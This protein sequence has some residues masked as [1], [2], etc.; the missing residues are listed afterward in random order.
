MW[1]C[2]LSC[3]CDTH[4]GSAL[5]TNLCWFS[6][7]KELALLYFCCPL[8][9]LFQSHT[10]MFPFV[11]RDSSNSKPPPPKKPSLD[12]KK[13]K[14]RCAGAGKLALLCIFNFMLIH[15]KHYPQV[16]VSTLDQNKN[17]S[18]SQLYFF[19][20]FFFFFFAGKT[21]VTL[22]PANL[23]NANQPTPNPTGRTRIC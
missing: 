14:H 17:A 5:G 13:E 16:C 20:S 3:G 1:Q 21:P 10:Q 18:V 23:W 2:L 6:V 15:V 4:A 22:S 9:E 11:R 12:V 7:H 19:S 8:L